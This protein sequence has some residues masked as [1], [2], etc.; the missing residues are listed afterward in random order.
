MQGSRKAAHTIYAGFATA[1]SLVTTI[2]LIAAITLLVF[3]GLGTIGTVVAT[4]VRCGHCV[5]IADSYDGAET[6]LAWLIVTIAI[7]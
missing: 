3:L 6:G 5:T 7:A 4:S 1:I 2:A